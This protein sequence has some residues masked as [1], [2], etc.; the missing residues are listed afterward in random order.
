MSANKILEA[1]KEAGVSIR[2]QTALDMIAQLRGT[3]N[4]SRFVRTFGNNTP[5]PPNLYDTA[6]TNT[7]KAFTFRVKINNAPEGFMSA[8][9]LGSNDPRAVNDVFAQAE[10][11]LTNEKYRG[12]LVTPDWTPDLTLDRVIKNPAFSESQTFSSFQPTLP[13]S[14]GGPT[15]PEGFGHGF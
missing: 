14:S 15:G 6:V 13:P 7:A 11:L 2:R 10:A 1:A 8:I 4:V 9:N 3:G 5:I 12:G